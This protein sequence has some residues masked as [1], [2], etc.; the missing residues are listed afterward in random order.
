MNFPAVPKTYYLLFIIFVLP[1][2]FP[3][4]KLYSCKKGRRQD[5]LYKTITQQDY[6]ER[7]CLK[8]VKLFQLVCHFLYHN[9]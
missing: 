1:S 8:F 9:R 4:H 2:A 6:D 5:A 3:W 7:F